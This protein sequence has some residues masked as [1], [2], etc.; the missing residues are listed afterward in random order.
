MLNSP[1]STTIDHRDADN[2]SANSFS[3][4]HIQ[5]NRWSAH[6][7]GFWSPVERFCRHS[8]LS[9]DQ[10]RQTDFGKLELFEKIVYFLQI[11]HVTPLGFSQQ[12]EAQQSLPEQVYYVAGCSR[13]CLIFNV[14][15]TL[16]A[17]QE[18]WLNVEIRKCPPTL[19]NQVRKAP[20]SRL[21]AVPWL[22]RLQAIAE[23]DCY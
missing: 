3:L 1:I 2:I 13:C 9:L 12:F 5:T 8:H 14:E 22:S 6:L 23:A 17:H 7:A 15:A 20:P 4:R 18:E 16:R 10:L 19:L 11:P 21:G